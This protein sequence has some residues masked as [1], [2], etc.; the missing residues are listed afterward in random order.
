MGNAPA[1]AREALDMVRAGLGYLAAALAVG[2][3]VVALML[4]PTL[5]GV[6]DVLW[7]LTVTGVVVLGL[8]LA[9]YLTQRHER[10]VEIGEVTN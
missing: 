5:S 2:A 9:G 7:A 8:C 3:L 4:P 6:R 1:C 10:G